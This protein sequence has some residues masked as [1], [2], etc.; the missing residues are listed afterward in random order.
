MVGDATDSFFEEQ[1]D[2]DLDFFD[3]DNNQIA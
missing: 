1:D 2:E 3:K